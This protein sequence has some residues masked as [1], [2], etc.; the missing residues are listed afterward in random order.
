MQWSELL[1]RMVANGVTQSE[2]ATR[3]GCSQPVISELMSGRSV[4]TKYFIGRA[5][6][7]FANECG[8]N[9]ADVQPNA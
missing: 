3:A 8:I 2:I 9:A 5:I 6:V 7:E 1:Q 4:D